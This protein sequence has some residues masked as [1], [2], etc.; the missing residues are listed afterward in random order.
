MEQARR[1]GKRRDLRLANNIQTF[2]TNAC[3]KVK[4]PA[5]K[6]FNLVRGGDERISNIKL[7][8]EEAGVRSNV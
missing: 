4:S 8:R 6:R 2:P 3:G 7:A 5:K 1:L